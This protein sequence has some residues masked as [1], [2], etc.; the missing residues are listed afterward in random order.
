MLIVA[1]IFEVDP[2]QRD[3]FLRSRED[4]MRASRAEPGCI[5]Y[6]FS[7]DPLEPDLVHLFERWESK[8]ALAGH[9]AGL[10]R[11][12]RPADDVSTVVREIQQY[13][14]ASF[15]PVGS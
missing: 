2:A 15:G 5:T 11:K 14:I 8:D 9:I 12:A 3:D 4:A 1:G 6:V 10:Q 7:A 13:E